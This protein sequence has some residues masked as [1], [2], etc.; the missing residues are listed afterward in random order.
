MTKT[1]HIYAL[2]DPRNPEEVQYIGKAD[3]PKSRLNS[4]ISDSLSIE[5][6]LCKAVWIRSVLN[7]NLKPEMRILEKVTYDNPIEW[8]D[9][10]VYYI[11]YY[12]SKGHRLENSTL[13]GA[14]N[15]YFEAIR[16]R[17][18]L[19]QKNKTLITKYKLDEAIMYTRSNR[20]E[21]E[22]AWKMRRDFY[23]AR[24]ECIESEI[25]LRVASHD[26]NRARLITLGGR[27]CPICG[28][29]IKEVLWNKHKSIFVDSYI[30]P[31]A[32]TYNEIDC[33]KVF[34]QHHDFVLRNMANI[35]KYNNH[36]HA[37]THDGKLITCKCNKDGMVFL[38]YNCKLFN[39]IRSYDKI[40]VN[41]FERE[42][43]A[44]MKRFNE[45]MDQRK[46]FDKTHTR[47]EL[48]ALRIL[49]VDYNSTNLKYG[50]SVLSKYAHN[51]ETAKDGKEALEKW[52]KRRFDII[53]MDVQ[54][55][56]MDGI[57]ATRIIRE[58]ESGTST[59]TTIIVMI[60][61]TLMKD[62]DQ[63]VSLGFDGY[64]S[65]PVQ[66]NSLHS[67]IIR[68]STLLHSCNNNTID[69]RDFQI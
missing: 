27:F 44:T 68:S 50:K 59:H 41:N 20:L 6:S 18:K 34:I 66:I 32:Y 25:S 40:R 2:Y 48:H 1:T 10:E 26:V 39:R 13:G 53:L 69:V 9:R 56:S 17:H 65:K 51:I 7:E 58:T 33:E 36:E 8:E 62:R 16:Y 63:I 55:P 57:E 52:G 37:F 61:P 29:S 15:F 19:W 30:Q 3:N 60:A 5:N 24:P 67:E 28:L 4:H 35:A 49:I 23:T 21:F 47:I 54:M 43:E 42:A 22:A 64:V 12:F 14:D 31:E 38:K 11:A 45:I 46:E